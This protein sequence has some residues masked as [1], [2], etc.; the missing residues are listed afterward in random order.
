MAKII[1]LEILVDSDDE[2]AIADG[3]NDMLR[4]AQL[5]VDPD[6][7]DQRSWVI[8]WRLAVSGGQMRLQSIPADVEDSIVNEAYSEGD[9]FRSTSAPL[10]PGIEYELLVESPNDADSLWIGVPSM[11][12]RTE[13]GDLSVLLKRTHEGAIV[14]I[15]PA[16]QEG[17][18]EILSSAAALY[19]D[20]ALPEEEFA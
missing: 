19:S 7:S 10:H 2:S 3:L 1:T 13:G 12:D 8:D 5:P 15:W 6:N 14:D 9:A 17:G 4:A 18:R 20:A 11:M 16:S